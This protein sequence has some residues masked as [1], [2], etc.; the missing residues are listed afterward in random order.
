MERTWLEW[1][2]Q[3]T[4]VVL[5]KITQKNYV[6]ANHKL[7][8]MIKNRIFINTLGTKIQVKLQYKPNNYCI[9]YNKVPKQVL[10]NRVQEFSKFMAKFDYTKQFWCIALVMKSTCHINTSTPKYFNELFVSAMIRQKWIDI[11]FE[12]LLL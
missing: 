6:K 4:C 1:F 9:K 5:F 12:C 8:N 3:T 10:D 11:S 7:F 2:M